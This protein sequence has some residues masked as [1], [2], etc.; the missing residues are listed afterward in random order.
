MLTPLTLNFIWTLCYMT[1]EVN[2]K[3]Q[4]INKVSFPKSHHSAA[5]SLKKKILSATRVLVE[6]KDELLTQEE[7]EGMTVKSTLLI[8]ADITL[9]DAEKA[10]VAQCAKEATE[11]P[12]ANDETIAQFTEATG[13]SV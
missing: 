6:G 9:T 7:A 10:W 3:G 11:Y 2:D 5:R 13:V 8:A 12:D 1:E 4:Q